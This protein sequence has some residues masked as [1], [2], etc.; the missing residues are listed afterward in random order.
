M[1]NKAFFRQRAGMLLCA[2]AC[3]GLLLPAQA[4]ETIPWPGDEAVTPCTSLVFGENAS[5]LDFF[6]GQLYVVDN[7][8]AALWI[9]DAQSDGTL[10]FASGMAGGRQIGFA[11]HTG[12]LAA[13]RPD[14]E[15]ITVDAEGM[16]Y[17]VAER[18]MA[19]PKVSQNTV[20]WVDPKEEGSIVAARQEWNLTPSLPEVS[21][22]RGLEGVEWIPFEAAEGRL[23]DQQTKALFDPENYP[24]SVSEGIIFVALEDNGHVDAYVLN[25]DGSY[26]QLADWDTELGG[27]MALEYDAYEDVLWVMT[28]NGYDN[29]GAQLRFNGTQ[30][31]D[32]VHVW[33]PAGV[34]IENN[35]EGFAIADASYTVQGQRPVYRLEDGALGGA[36]TIGSLDCRYEPEEAPARGAG[37]GVALAVAVVGA[38]LCG[39]A[40]LYRRKHR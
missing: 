29:L 16:V 21:A 34:D 10:S 23:W 15:G 40:V 4:A 20:L 9:V 37:P 18:D 27:A 31:P 33:P 38:L 8:K 11:E 19:E 7:E 14:A 35:T 22:N 39:S 25:E 12:H 28:D 26:A 24:H 6:N 30:Q 2:W 1:R 5:G 17:I 32:V 36:L 13:A 3:L